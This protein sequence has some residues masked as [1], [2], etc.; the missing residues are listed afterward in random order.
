MEE[1]K[2]S[3][4]DS[5]AQIEAMV[6]EFSAS[7][8]SMRQNIDESRKIRNEIEN[9]VTKHDETSVWSVSES[10]NNTSVNSVKDINPEVVI[11]E[12]APP[13]KLNY[14]TVQKSEDLLNSNSPHEPDLSPQNSGKI[15]SCASFDHMIDERGLT[16]DDIED[17]EILDADNDQSHHSALSEISTPTKPTTPG[18]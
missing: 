10:S 7:L 17:S 15:T 9:D 14:K 18:M 4:G 2:L 6:K 5:D 11:P 12:S 16:N 1:E 13:E 8:S 3:E